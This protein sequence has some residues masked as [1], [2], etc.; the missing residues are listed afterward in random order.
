MLISTT[1]FI[2]RN[3]VSPIIR[4]LWIK[5]VTGR[6]NIP[7]HEGA[8]VALNHQSYLDFL[9]FIS[10]SKRNIYFLSAEKFFTNKLWLPLMLITGQIR[11]NREGKDKSKT[12]NQVF[13]SL[14]E[15]KLVG[16]FPEGTRSPDPE[17]MLPG[18]V[19]VARYALNA[20]VDIVPVGV[21]GAFEV[22]SRFDKRP[23]FGKK[24]EIFV[25]EPIKIE[26]YKDRVKND[27]TY[28]EITEVVMHKISE[29]SGKKLPST[30]LR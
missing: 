21:V 3:I 23:K 28:R 2:V 10:I 25:G 14:E 27:E 11:V 30:L 4:L 7:S 6:K 17:S 13:K 5:K 16:I 29:L 9:C 24:I 26:S 1:Y 22:M 15:G 12:H 8:V 18:F 20:G 19:G